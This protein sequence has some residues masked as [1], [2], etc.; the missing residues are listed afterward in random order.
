MWTQS[1]YFQT[2]LF[3]FPIAVRPMNSV[4]LARLCDFLRTRE[5]S[6]DELAHELEF[7]SELTPG[8]CESGRAFGDFAQGLDIAKEV[9]AL[10]Q[11][12]AKAHEMLAPNLKELHCLSEVRLEE[13][14]EFEKILMNGRPDG[15]RKFAQWGMDLFGRVYGG[16]RMR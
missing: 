5:A 7:A 9:A 10:A 11:T 12:C 6:P 14:A 2:F 1:A 15:K 4:V 8:G 16:G 13:A 3:E